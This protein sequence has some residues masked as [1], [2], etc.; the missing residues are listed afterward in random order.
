[1]VGRLPEWFER[2]PWPRWVDRIPWPLLVVLVVQACLSGRLLWADTAFIDEATYLYA[3]HQ[4]IHSIL[5]NGALTV[6]GANGYYQTYFSGAPVLYPILGAI[7]DSIGGLTAA[8]LLS[9]VFMLGATSF[10]YGTAARLFNRRAALFGS[11][12]FAILGPTQFLGALA[13]YDAMALCLMALAAYLAVKSSQLDDNRLTL[14]YACVAMVMADAV[15]YAVL[16]F[17]PV[18]LGAC[19]L[20]CVPYRGWAQARRQGYRMLGYSATMLGAL[21]ALGGHAYVKGLMY[22]TLSRAAGTYSVRHILLDS[23]GWVGAVAVAAAIAVIVHIIWDRQS[24][25]RT[26]LCALL[27]A[28]VTLAPL[29]Q[30]RIHTLTSLQKHVDFGAWFAAIAVGYLLSRVLPAARNRAVASLTLLAATAALSAVTMVSAAQ[31]TGLATEWPN[32]DATVAALSPWAKSGNV[33]A[34]NYFIYI[35]YLGDNAASL[36]RWS[37]TWE[38][39]YKDPAS[40]KELTGYAAYT[41]AIMHHHFTTVAVSYGAT[42][43]TDHVIINAMKKA[44]GYTRVVHIRFGPLWFDVFHE[45]NAK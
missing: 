32:S 26:L 8:R 20:A 40:G 2:V 3:G 24:L 28:A 12:V 10:L 6:P 15:K 23:W 14:L 27:A 35:Y 43:A 25:S 16:L 39:T 19:V 11:A 31:A 45:T 33:L 30:A 36:D 18:I 21:L 34:E 7:A 44:G 42:S 38:L 13:T 17:D 41:D 4:E 1:L 5:T 22:T 29:D 9:L 37:D